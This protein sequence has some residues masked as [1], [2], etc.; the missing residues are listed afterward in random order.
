[1]FIML[2]I[3]IRKKNDTGVGNKS[4][5]QYLFLKL[6]KKNIEIFYIFW[7]YFDKKFYNIL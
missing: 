5:N 7:L 6:R 2:I 4:I 3:L 1:M